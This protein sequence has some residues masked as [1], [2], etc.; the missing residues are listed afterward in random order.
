MELILKTP[1]NIRISD[2]PDIIYRNTSW[3]SYHIWLDFFMSEKCPSSSR[4]IFGFEK[5]KKLK[6]IARERCE[7][8]KRFP[9]SF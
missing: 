3:A 4:N 2:R 8:L 6:G 7:K 9:G 5:E 1:K